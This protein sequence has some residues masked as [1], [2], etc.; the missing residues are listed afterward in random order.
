[1]EN[2]IDKQNMEIQRLNECRKEDHESFD[3][4]EKQYQEQ[5]HQMTMDY[6]KLQETIKEDKNEFV[7]E[8]KSLV[9]Y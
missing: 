5:I 1:M 4:I 3:S 9:L 2:V 6:G 7:K 8:M